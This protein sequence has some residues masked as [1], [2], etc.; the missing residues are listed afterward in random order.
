MSK[1]KKQIKMLCGIE[2][3]SNL[4]LWNVLLQAFFVII[5]CIPFIT[6]D[7]R[8]IVMLL[9]V[10]TFIL[11]LAVFCFRCKKFNYIATFKIYLAL[12]FL[13]LVVFGLIIILSLMQ[14]VNIFIEIV[15]A[16]WMIIFFIIGFLVIKITV[17]FLFYWR[18]KK[19][20]PFE[21]KNP[22][23]IEISLKKLSPY[24]SL[25][26]QKAYLMI[27][28]GINLIVYVFYIYFCFLV[29]K[30]S[31]F[32]EVPVLKKVQAYIVNWSFINSSN[33]IGLFSIFIAL[34]TIC[35]PAQQK[36]VREAEKEMLEKY[37]NN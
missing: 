17:K 4:E 8:Y 10:I 27:S 35:V 26:K 13:I 21:G 19:V 15:T 9:L 6:V 37:N 20:F 18:M 28:Y 36:I 22:A 12:L 5:V 23:Q 29:F 3:L 30:L 24:I 31:I 33:A 7:I 34:V 2:F 14:Q 32:T 11:Q 1:S 25:E 16:C